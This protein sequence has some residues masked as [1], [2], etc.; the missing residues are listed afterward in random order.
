MA[1]RFDASQQALDLNNIRTDPGDYTHL[2]KI[3]LHTFATRITRFIL[4]SKFL[5]SLT[6][7]MMIV[8]VITILASLQNGD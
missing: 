4:I 7:M 8:I 3:F 5:T 2:L 6:E 1:K